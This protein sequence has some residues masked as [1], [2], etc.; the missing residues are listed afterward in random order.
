MRFWDSSA[1]VPLVVVEAASARLVAYVAESNPMYI[2]WSTRIEV[3]AAL[4]RRERADARRDADWSA[5]FLALNEMAED[6]RE[7][8]PTDPVRRSAERLLRR[9]DLCAVASLQLAA[10]LIACD[11]LPSGQEFICL[12]AR[13]RRAA[14][15]EG[16]RLLPP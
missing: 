13:L 11:D 4:T 5:C 7:V 2:W 9:H 8:L 1:I 12:D 14:A 15:A 3:T 16:F 6:W 10:A